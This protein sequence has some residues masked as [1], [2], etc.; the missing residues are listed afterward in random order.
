MNIK[1][2]KHPEKKS[3][4]TKQVIEN[5][6]ETLTNNNLMTVTVNDGKKIHNVVIK[7]QSHSLIQ[8]STPV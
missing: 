8:S 1:P 3:R 2:R 6:R 5:D 7:T 4:D